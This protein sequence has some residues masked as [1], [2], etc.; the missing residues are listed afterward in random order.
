MCVTIKGEGLITGT[1]SCLNTVIHKEENVGNSQKLNYPEE[2]FSN[3]L[4]TCSRN[5]LPKAHHSHHKVAFVSVHTLKHLLPSYF[6]Q[7][8]VCEKDKK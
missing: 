2:H 8:V 4:F 7:R 5:F 1:G 6:I 3:Y